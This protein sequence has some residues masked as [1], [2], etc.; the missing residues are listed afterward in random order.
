MPSER[1]VGISVHPTALSAA[2]AQVAL[3][4]RNP[5]KLTAAA[6]RIDSDR[7][8]LTVA[9]RRHRPQHIHVLHG[10]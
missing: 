1:H 7:P 3:V 8:S 2:G 4:A 10:A 5:D 9:D 6:Q